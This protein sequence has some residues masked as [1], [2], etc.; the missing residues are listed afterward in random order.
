MTKVFILIPWFSPAFKAGGPVQSIANLVELMQGELFEFSIFCSNKDLDGTG[1]K[2]ITADTWVSYSPNT[3]V[4]Y[5]SCNNILP[6]LKQ[7]IKE[8]QP[9]SIYINGLFDWNYNLKPILFCKGVNK[10]ISP[11]GML[12]KGAVEGKAWKKKP[13][14]KLLKYSGRVNNACWLAT[15]EEEKNDIR[16]YFPQARNIII[17]PNI[18]K[19][20]V[21]VIIAS[22]KKVGNLRLVYL[23]LI[24]KK[25]NLHL[26]LQGMIDSGI[27]SVSLDI[28]GPIKDRVYWEK[29][30]LPLISHLIDRANYK[31]ELDPGK[32]QSTLA[33]YDA[34]VLLTKGENFGHAIYESLSTSRPVIISDYTPWNDL[35]K[36]RAGWNIDIN[37]EKEF[38]SVLQRLVQMDK[39]EH[40]RYCE[41]AFSRAKEYYEMN[42]F[43]NAY[44][45]MFGSPTGK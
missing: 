25:K 42:D 16:E 5:S 19:R 12:Q 31:G 28:Y 44:T 23:S 18:P 4:F 40:Q 3:R 8:V 43:K 36:T 22:Q 21:A 41:G 13:F 1:L 35:E 26:I 39:P 2:G 14:L 6:R 29:D 7:Q 20:P 11:R 15:N 17:A 38:V 30:C 33:G 37:D 45:V 34:F 27:Q 24:A 10:I 9:A 32:V